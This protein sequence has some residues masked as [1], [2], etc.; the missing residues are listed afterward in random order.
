MTKPLV[1][2]SF[3]ITREQ[4]DNQMELLRG[5]NLTTLK[6]NESGLLVPAM[7]VQQ[8]ADSEIAKHAIRLMLHGIDNGY[9]PEEKKD[10]IP[11]DL[12][13]VAQKCQNVFEAMN[14]TDIPSF[15]GS[16]ANIVE[17]E[18]K[19]TSYWPFFAPSAISPERALNNGS[20]DQI[21]TL[22]KKNEDLRPQAVIQF[23]RKYGSDYKI[24]QEK[25]TEFKSL[26]LQTLLEIVKDTDRDLGFVLKLLKLNPSILKDRGAQEIVKTL[27][28]RL[29]HLPLIK[30]KNKHME[31]AIEILKQASIPENIFG[32]DEKNNAQGD[33][34]GL[35]KPGIKSTWFFARR[36]FS[37]ID[38]ASDLGR[39]LREIGYNLEKKSVVRPTMV[40]EID[41]INHTKN[42]QV[43]QELAREMGMEVAKFKMQE[44]ARWEILHKGL[45]DL[46]RDNI[47]EYDYDDILEM[48]EYLLPMTVFALQELDEQENIWERT[49]YSQVSNVLNKLQYVEDYPMLKRTNQYL[50]DRTSGT[51]IQPVHGHVGSW[52]KSWVEAIN[53]K[54]KNGAP[55]YFTNTSANSDEIMELVLQGK[56][57]KEIEEA[58]P[59]YTDTAKKLAGEALEIAARG[60]FEGTKILVPVVGNILL[61]GAVLGVSALAYALKNIISDSGAS[62]ATAPNQPLP[63][64]QMHQPLTI[65]QPAPAP[66]RMEQAAAVAADFGPRLIEAMKAS[67]K[68]DA[69]NGSKQVVLDGK[70]YEPEIGAPQE[71]GGAQEGIELRWFGS[72]KCRV[73][74]ESNK[75]ITVLFDKSMRVIQTNPQ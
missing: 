41:G 65:A 63:A 48:E 16:V 18:I 14:L 3:P 6:I 24:E 21:R 70:T 2:Y 38:P 73:V 29:S 12:Q 7:Q 37:S 17:K 30:N 22:I 27:I 54:T 45:K 61:K 58:Y 72:G 36:H 23:L 50:A 26:L 62:S 10:K 8:S 4:Y 15:R 59:S 68:M 39:F 13:D 44:I 33:Y 71:L 60:T 20:K 47:K 35:T 67:R 40:N 9:H 42:V 1:T 51:L 66:L 53:D 57:P 46:S 69:W 5:H 34:Q 56:S 64:E 31:H 52:D 55:L 75:R 28:K 19:S 49:G 25:E 32:F 74:T 11:A 43:R